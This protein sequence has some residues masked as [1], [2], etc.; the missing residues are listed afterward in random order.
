LSILKRSD[1]KESGK[2]GADFFQ[3]LEYPRNSGSKSSNPWKTDP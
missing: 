1:P 3:T 2:N